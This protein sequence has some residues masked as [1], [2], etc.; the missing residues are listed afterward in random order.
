MSIRL[1]LEGFSDH[2]KSWGGKVSNQWKVRWVLESISQK[3]LTFGD[4]SWKSSPKTST[5]PGTMLVCELSPK[6]FGMGFLP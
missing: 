3:K 2:F 1:K 5:R 4:S 6:G